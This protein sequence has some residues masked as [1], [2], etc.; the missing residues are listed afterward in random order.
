MTPANRVAVA[1]GLKSTAATLEKLKSLEG[2]IG[3]A[4]IRLDLMEEFDL[5][6]LIENSPCPLVMTCRAQREGGAYQGP[7]AQRLGILSEASA[8]GCAY[9][10]VEWDCVASFR[11]QGESTKV[12]ASRHFHDRMPGDL[13]SQYG[14]MRDQADVVKLVGTAGQAADALPILELIVR[15][16]SPLIAIAM[17]ASGLITRLVAPCFDSCLLTYAAADD[18][19][20]TAPGQ[21]SVREM[22]E[23]FGVDRVRPDT[24][25]D[26]F[27]YSDP[28]HEQE[29]FSLCR[30]NGSRLKVPLRV[31]S[32]QIEYMRRALEELTPRFNGIALQ[33]D[34]ITPS[35][36]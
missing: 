24:P 34:T 25:I 28:G 19:R 32:G 7:E 17:G 27:L 9:V 6:S 14:D 31:E 30:G 22:T 13:W 10:D 16:K 5:E 2:H 8:S 3:L 35:G 11:N 4:E 23:H 36:E 20:G 1:L 21:I 26:V 33:A 29:A 18:E 15:A 12:I